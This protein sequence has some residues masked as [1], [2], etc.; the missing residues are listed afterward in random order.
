VA[1]PVLVPAS[2]SALFAVLARRQPPRRAYNVGFGA[3]WLGWC[4]AF[5]L[6]AIGPRRAI[7]VL[8]RGRRPAAGDAVALLL[9]VLGAAASELFPHRRLV[10]GR[11][12]AVMATTAAVNAAAEEMLWRGVFLEEFPDDPVLGSLWPLAGFSVWHLAP[13]IVLPSRFGRVGFLLAAT[14]V[15]AGSARV[16]WRTGGLRWVLLPHAATDF[17]GVTAARFRLDGTR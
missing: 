12:L 4:L 15:G 1:A 7:G 14:A 8:T 10:R 11:V 2:M 16:A 6:W 9:P 5:P 17:C 13:Q 3:Y